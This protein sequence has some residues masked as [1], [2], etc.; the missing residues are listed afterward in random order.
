MEAI[1]DNRKDASDAGMNISQ[2]T[3]GILAIKR[4]EGEEMVVIPAVGQAQQQ[5]YAPGNAPMQVLTSQPAQPTIIV[6]SSA[7]K[8][9]KK[10]EKKVSE[11]FKRL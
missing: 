6:I 9:D 1:M 3:Q 5:Y 11:V 7:K 10:K 8:K 4:G 2:P